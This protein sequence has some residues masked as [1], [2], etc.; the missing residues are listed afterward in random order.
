MM[1][2]DALFVS[3]GD[4]ARKGE[5][6]RHLL[7]KALAILGRSVLAMAIETDR[8]A[9]RRGPKVIFLSQPLGGFWQKSS[10]SREVQIVTHH[11]A[12]VGW[13]GTIF[14][15]HMIGHVPAPLDIPKHVADVVF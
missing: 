4:V 8:S 3:R 12:Q 6:S 10:V 7:I 1:P 14:D 11:T 9:A 15:S 2:P 13:L 5:A